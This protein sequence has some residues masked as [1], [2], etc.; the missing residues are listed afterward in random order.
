MQVGDGIVR[1]M[2]SKDACRGSQVSSG[3]FGHR[4]RETAAR[5]DERKL[6]TPLRFNEIHSVRKGVVG[7]R[8]LRTG[9]A[10]ASSGGSRSGGR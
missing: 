4:R 2:P 3:K 10:G 1:T 6:K 8:F 9:R 5:Q 7:A